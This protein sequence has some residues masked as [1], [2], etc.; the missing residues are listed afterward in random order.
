MIGIL[1]G[2]LE[3]LKNLN[4]IQI[5]HHSEKNVNKNVVGRRE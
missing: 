3:Q 5:E 1:D 2:A 4:T